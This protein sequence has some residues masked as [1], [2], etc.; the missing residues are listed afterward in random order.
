MKI[1][2]A[3][4][5]S[6]K[7][8]EILEVVGDLP[9]EFVSL[10]DVGITED[11]EETGITHEENALLK[12]KFYNSKTGLPTIGEDSGIYV[13]AFPGDFGVYT[14]RWKGLHAAG[15]DEWIRVFLEEIAKISP[16]KRTA[17]FVCCAA[18]YLGDTAQ[19]IMVRGETTGLITA[20]L[21]A[22]LIPG[23]PISSC[24]IPDGY[25]QVYA[26]LTVGEKNAVSHRGKALA[27]LKQKIVSAEK[28]RKQG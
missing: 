17:R 16:E 7:L 21:R 14:R 23:I 19:P 5:N 4:H 26:A 6:G 3:T 12:A 24:F 8:R 13:D 2:V 10:K 15:D 18:Y 27:E 22:P 11:V 28:I 20:E 25:S 1:L 9:A